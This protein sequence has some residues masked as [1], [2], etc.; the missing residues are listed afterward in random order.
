MS[1]KLRAEVTQLSIE[2]GTERA[3]AG[4][5]GLAEVSV[6][7]PAARG[8]GNVYLLVQ[9]SGEPVGKEAIHRELID[10]IVE[11]YSRIP[12]GVTNGLRQAI[13]AG[14]HFLYARNLESLPLWQRFG[15][16]CCAVLRGNELY[17]G[18][19]GEAQL[20]VLRQGDVRVF[21]PSAVDTSVK[22]MGA[23]HRSLPPL[24][25]DE[26]L[27][28][29]GL[30]HYSIEEGDLIVLASSGLP[31]IASESRLAR[32]AQGGARQLLDT[33]KSLASHTDL[34]VLLIEVRAAGVESVPRSKTA[35]LDARAVTTQTRSAGV[36]SKK[37]RST[38]PPAKGI[39]AG[40][41]AVLLA[42]GAGILALFAGLARAVQVFFSWLL[43]SGFLDKLGRGLRYGLVSLLQGMGTLTK[44]MLPESEPV[45]ADVAGP[46]V[47]RLVG[48]TPEEKSSRLPLLLVLAIVAIVV[49]VSGGLAMRTQ[50]RNAQVSQLIQDAQAQIQL[51]QT[52]GT[53][54]DTRRSLTQALGY[55]DEALALKPGHAEATA[56]REEA[57]MSL[58]GVNRVV[59]LVFSGQVPFPD[60]SS[61]PKHVLLHDNQIYVIDQGTQTLHSYEADSIRGTLDAAAGTVLLSPSNQPA[62]LVIEKLTDFA[63][64]GEG[65]GRETA[66]LLVLVNDASLLQLDSSQGLTQVSIADS[67][68][69]GDARLIEGYS[70]YLYV[71]DAQEDRIL[72]YAP[73]GNSYDSFPISYF[74]PDTVV[75]LEGA[76]DMAIDGYIYVLVGSNILRF[77]GGV[78]ERFSVSGLEDQDLQN[79]VAVYTSPETQHIYVADAGAGRIVQLTKEGAFVRQFFPPRD[80]EGVFQSLQGLFVDEA[81]GLMVALTAEGLFLAPIEQTS[82]AI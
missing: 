60:P 73:T 9:V 66:S 33:L 77:S 55:L 3:A 61:Q 52:S 39:A 7:I 57:L 19:A 23:A 44:R 40:L 24:G 74:Q 51:A 79:P 54:A 45:P 20:Y 76:V 72:K 64:V 53:P 34:S 35:R 75:D 68:A 46:H 70:G 41:V 14:N 27:R 80:E 56:L 30:Y 12:G 15:E 47:R 5:S 4:D 37:K 62:G 67:E 48:V 29:V 8:K 1:P 49:A 18:V 11:S 26:F 43:S 25:V 71:L 32:A 69:W 16:T 65:S 59:R 63:W 82:T 10:V 6:L 36:P 78:E 13:R 38:R 28:E 31:R 2:S 22:A 81:Q 42:L 21:P 50:A 17:M 58:D